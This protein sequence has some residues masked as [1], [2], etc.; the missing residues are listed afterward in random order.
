[1]YVSL[2]Q[3]MRWWGESGDYYITANYKY[4]CKNRPEHHNGWVVRDI[5]IKLRVVGEDPN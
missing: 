3:V 2:V 5:G 4:L 1:M